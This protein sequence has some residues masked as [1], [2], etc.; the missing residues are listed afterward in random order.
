MKK[1]Y[2]NHSKINDEDSV[3]QTFLEFFFIGVKII[4]CFCYIY[5]IKEFLLALND[6]F[7]QLE[8]KLFEILTV[9]IIPIIIILGFG[10]HLLITLHKRKGARIISNGRK[11]R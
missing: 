3:G 4:I 5:L 9:Q 6:T 11:R 7:F 2:N 8:G 1:N 10:F